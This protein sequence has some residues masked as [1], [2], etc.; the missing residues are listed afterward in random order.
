M[1]VGKDFMRCWIK[2]NNLDLPK[3]I[4]LKKPNNF[5]YLCGMMIMISNDS[6]DDKFKMI[7][8]RF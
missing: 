6:Q 8:R 2:E 1:K 4:N 3:N 7:S 5:L